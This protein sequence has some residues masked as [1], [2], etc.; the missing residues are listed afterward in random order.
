[1]WSGRGCTADAVAVLGANL[2]WGTG[3]SQAVV[4][5]S[6]AHHTHHFEGPFHARLTGMFAFLVS[7]PTASPRAVCL[8]LPFF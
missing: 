1:M 7:L 8:D 6:Q 3:D 5:G 2:A 4:V